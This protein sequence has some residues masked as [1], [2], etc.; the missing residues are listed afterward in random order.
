M[1]LDS[2]SPLG[3]LGRRFESCRPDSYSNGSQQSESQKS[4]ENSVD[5]Y[6]N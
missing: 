3:A 6:G 1:A 5:I 2:S 4:V